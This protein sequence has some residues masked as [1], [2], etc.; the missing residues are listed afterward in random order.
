MLDQVINSFSDI[1]QNAGLDHVRKTKV[2]NNFKKGKFWFDE[3][4]QVERVK[5][6]K[7][8][9]LFDLDDTDENRKEMCKQRSFYRKVCRKKRKLYNV[10]QAENLLSL[11]KKNPRLFWKKYKSMKS[12]AN[13]INSNLNFF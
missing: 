11:S 6:L 8:K 13:K 10:S 9:Q 12:Q 3:D 4:C 2:D 5:F 7:R 1:I